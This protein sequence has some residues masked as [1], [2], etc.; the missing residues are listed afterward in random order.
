MQRIQAMAKKQEYEFCVA[1][2]GNVNKKKGI[3]EHARVFPD[4]KSA[5][6]E[7]ARCGDGYKLFKRAVNPWE[8]VEKLK[9]KFPKMKHIDCR[10]VKIASIEPYKETKSDLKARAECGNWMFPC[11]SYLYNDIKAGLEQAIC[12]VLGVK[13]C[14]VKSF[15]TGIVEFDGTEKRQ[16]KQG[17]LKCIVGGVV[18]KAIPPDCYN[19]KS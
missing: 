16:P 9:F 10:M 5:E 6:E 8:E 1:Y 2:V 7:L 13:S 3:I 4:Q 17:S 12:E 14:T 11:K 19:N 15:E 18:N